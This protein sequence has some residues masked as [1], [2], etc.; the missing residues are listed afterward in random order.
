MPFDPTTMSRRVGVA[1]VRHDSNTICVVP[2][3]VHRIVSP[4]GKH[5]VLRIDRWTFGT[6]DPANGVSCTKMTLGQLTTTDPRDIELAA[7]FAASIP[8]TISVQFSTGMVNDL[9]VNLQP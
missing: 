1:D 7:L 5:I 6:I 3:T 8:I 4:R 9:V 2:W